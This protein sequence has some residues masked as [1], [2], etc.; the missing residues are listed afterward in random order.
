MTLET[1]SAAVEEFHRRD[2]VQVEMSQI[3]VTRARPA[4]RYHLMDANNPVWLL[5]G[6]GRA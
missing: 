6:E 3:A 5:S 1:L 4:G 2:L